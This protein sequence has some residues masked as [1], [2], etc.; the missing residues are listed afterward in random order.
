MNPST[1]P[2]SLLSPHL[3]NMETSSLRLH[4]LNTPLASLVGLLA[5]GGGIYGLIDPMAFSPSS[6]ALP[7]VSFA[8]AR[9][10]SSGITLL[11]LLYTGQRKAV[12]VFLMSGVVAAM[13][14]A[15]ICGACSGKVD[16]SNQCYVRLVPHAPTTETS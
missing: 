1:P 8:G 14:Y 7:F 4:R 16:K 6:P 3:L 10:V 11:T 9:N 12:G 2:I 15:W 5:V 13:A